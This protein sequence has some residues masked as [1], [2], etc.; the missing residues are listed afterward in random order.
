MKA[1]VDGKFYARKNMQP[2]LPSTRHWQMRQ[3]PLPL[4]LSDPPD[5]LQP[6]SSPTSHVI[7]LARTKH[8][9]PFTRS[10]CLIPNIPLFVVQLLSHILF[11]VTP[12]IAAHQASLSFTIFQSLLKFMSTGLMIPSNHLILFCPLFLL[13]SIFPMGLFQ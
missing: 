13:P 1:F 11:L 8:R 5:F 7:S 12:R 6:T 3:A 4:Y 2:Y 9:V 10:S